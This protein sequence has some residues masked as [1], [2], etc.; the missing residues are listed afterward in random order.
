MHGNWSIFINSW[1]FRGVWANESWGDIANG[2][3]KK[4]GP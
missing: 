4:H 1:Y 2:T 3:P